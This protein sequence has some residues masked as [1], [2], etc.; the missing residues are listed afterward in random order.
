MNIHYK[1]NGVKI[2][3]SNLPDS[4][5]RDKEEQE[6]LKSM[7]KD[8]ISSL[9]I[10][11]EKNISNNNITKLETKESKRPVNDDRPVI[12]GRVPNKIDLSEFNITN[13]E[14]KEYGIRCP[15]C[16]Q[17]SKAIVMLGLDGDYYLRK[18]N[19]NGK[20][21]YEAILKLENDEIDQMCKKEDVD[22]LVYHKDIM[23]IK[24]A[25]ELRG[26]DINIDKHTNI[27][28][29]CCGNIDLYSLW[30]K[31]YEEPLEVGFE[32]DNLCDICGGEAVD[33]ID[34]D[35]KHSYKC[36]VCGYIKNVV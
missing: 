12:R 25:K 7:I 5:L 17:S 32:S 22:P 26:K 3:L 18:E 30:I 9:E 34:K 35:K 19:K 10:E 29:P 20:E 27:K 14:V 23:E 8:L 24:Q 2:V 33:Y 11:K 15:E 1:N 36:E 4:V 28:C 13:A 16:G 31:A 6:A 21:T